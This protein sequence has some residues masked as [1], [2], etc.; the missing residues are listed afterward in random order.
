LLGGLAG[1]G[2]IIRALLNIFLA[3]EG[4]QTPAISRDNTLVRILCACLVH[5]NIEVTGMSGVE[6]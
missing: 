2:G 1:G 3:R 6:E 5:L 4:V